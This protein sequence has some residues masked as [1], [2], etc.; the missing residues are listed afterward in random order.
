M[1][2]DLSKRVKVEITEAGGISFGLP[3]SWKPKQ[4]QEGEGGNINYNTI[5][6]PLHTTN[7]MKI[8]LK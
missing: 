7:E 3:Y 6:Q 4:N 2:N 8:Y 5:N 1:L